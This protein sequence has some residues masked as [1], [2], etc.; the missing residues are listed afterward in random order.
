M[1]HKYWFIISEVEMGDT[2]RHRQHG[3]RISLLIY[4]YIYI[5]IY[6]FKIMKVGWKFIKP[7]QLF[8][9]LTSVTSIENS[10]GCLNI[11]YINFNNLIPLLLQS[12]TVPCVIEYRADRKE[13]PAS[14]IP[15]C[16]R[17]SIY[18]RGNRFT[19]PLP[20][21][22]RGGETHQGDWFISLFTFFRN[23]KSWLKFIL[24][25]L[26]GVEWTGFIW[27]RIGTGEGLLRT[28]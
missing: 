9:I 26:D 22:G 23:K 7:K 19:D 1:F 14:N 2:Q 28:R 6:I 17:V 20:S 18:C 16:L 5:Y 4:I 12:L 24:E 15:F 8:C 13:N 27:L 3:D 10:M 11:C 21:N 25:K